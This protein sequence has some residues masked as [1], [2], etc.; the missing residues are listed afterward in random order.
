MTHTAPVATEREWELLDII[1][2]I[3][4]KGKVQG[5]DHVRLLKLGIDL[6]DLSTGMG[7]PEDNDISQGKYTDWLAFW[8]LRRWANESRGLIEKRRHAPTNN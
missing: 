4:N 2:S 7:T 8:A 5:N 6:E 3:S 1:H